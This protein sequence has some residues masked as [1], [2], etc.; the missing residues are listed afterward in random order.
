[1]LL[2]LTE[3]IDLGQTSSPEMNHLMMLQMQAIWRAG[4]GFS[5]DGGSLGMVQRLEAL[6]REQRY[7]LRR[8]PHVLDF[9]ATAEAWADHH[10]NLEIIAL[11]M[12]PVLVKYQLISP[13]AFHDLLRRAM[14]ALYQK[15]FQGSVQFFS[16]IGRSPD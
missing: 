16:L 9:S 8:V 13:E 12:E 11:Q 4:Y 10:K 15:D 1:G 2:R 14:I 3:P 6:L 5:E 7:E